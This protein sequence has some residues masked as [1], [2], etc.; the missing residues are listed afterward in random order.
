[1]KKRIIALLLLLSALCAVTSCADNS[2]AEPPAGYNPS[3]SDSAATTPA[4]SNPAVSDPDDTADETDVPDEN[5]RYI[6]FPLV[7]SDDTTS[8]VSLPDPAVDGP[9]LLEFFIVPAYNVDGEL[10]S[11]F[12]LPI[13]ENGQNNLQVIT[14]K[15]KGKD[16]YGLIFMLESV[17]IS[18]MDGTET[19]YVDMQCSS[20]G[21]VPDKM[22]YGIPNYYLLQGGD[23]VRFEYTDKNRQSMLARYKATNQVAL[24]RSKKLIQQYDDP[25]K[26]EYT[27]LYSYIDG[28]ETINT[29]VEEI[30]D[31]DFSLFNEYGFDHD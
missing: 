31:F 27:I 23:M 5:P 29:P 17:C 9:Q 20:L 3:E 28:V 30:P 22:A 13:R 24:E 18:E 16:T 21:F 14:Y 8:Y 12:K 7:S 19:R 26:Y 4:E 1:M 10:V 25:E 6:Q 15:E 2:S 11:A